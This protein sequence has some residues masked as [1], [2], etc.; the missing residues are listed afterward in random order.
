M[1]GEKPYEVVVVHGGPGAPGSMETVAKELSKRYSVLEP[2]QSAHSVNGQVAELH[3]FI[4][5][6]C[7]KGKVKIVGHS[8]GAWLAYMYTAIHPENIEKLIL[9]AAG[10]FDERYNFNLTQ[11]RLSRLNET[12]RKEALDII[13]WMNKASVDDPAKMIRFSELMEQADFYDCELTENES[14]DFQ[15]DVFQSVWKEADRLRRFGE[16]M[17]YGKK[18]KCPVIAI[19]GNYDT[20][21]A[22]GV[23]EPL[24]KLLKKKFKFIGLDQCGHYP[25]KERYA[26]EKFFEVLETELA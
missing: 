13:N 16:L 22:Q 6:N 18:I 17:Q 2:F 7:S 14:T 9:V 12:N 15:F 25:W 10:S 21:P 24:S 4:K 3:E 23:E 20:H 1:Y 19:H 11:I 5:E 8:W 26:R